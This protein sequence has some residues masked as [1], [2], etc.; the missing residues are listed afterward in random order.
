MRKSIVKEFRAELGDLLDAPQ[1]YDLHSK[2]LYTLIYYR[3]LIARP[4]LIVC[5]QPLSGVSMYTRTYI[6]E[7]IT[8]LC[9][10]GIAVLTL[11]T[12]LYDTL[13]AADRVIQVE[14]GHIIGEYLRSEFEMLRITNKN[15]Y[16]D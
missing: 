13:Y 14:S 6:L 8:K 11:N 5:V 3:Y 16:P 9:N 12:E 10:K 7:M 1:L 15:I 2:D 4:K